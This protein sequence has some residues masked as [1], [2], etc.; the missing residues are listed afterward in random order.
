MHIK[1]FRDHN[2][3]DLCIP[4]N[5]ESVALGLGLKWV[6]SGQAYRVFLPLHQNY[7][8]VKKSQLSNL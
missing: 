7:E 3:V 4:K 2:K 1:R 6:W 5:S 8:G